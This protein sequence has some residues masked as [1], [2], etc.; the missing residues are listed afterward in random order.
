MRACKRCRPDLF[1]RGEDENIALFEGLAA[2]VRAAPE[3]FADASALARAAGVS[4][5]KLGDLF[6][7][8][9]HLAPA[10]MAAARTRASCAPTCFSAGNAKV[11]DVG[12]RRGL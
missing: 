4:L 2:R 6:R 3:D 9:A 12:F 5:T 1:Y 8:H 10:H 11:V 7:D